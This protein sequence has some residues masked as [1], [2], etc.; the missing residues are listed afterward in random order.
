M[1]FK[2]IWSKIS[3][4]YVPDGGPA[5]IRLETEIFFH[6]KGAGGGGEMGRAVHGKGG[7]WGKEERPRLGELGFLKRRKVR[8]PLRL[9]SFLT[10]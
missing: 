3:E 6:K 10:L 8:C 1:Q 2:E 5:N 7:D 4:Y 9:E